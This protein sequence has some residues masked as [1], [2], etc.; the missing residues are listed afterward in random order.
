MRGGEY[1]PI[2]RR[3]YQAY[4]QIYRFDETLEGEA[5]EQEIERLARLWLETNHYL[6]AERGKDPE[7][8]EKQIFGRLML[9]DFFRR[10]VGWAPDEE[11]RRQKIDQLHQNFM[12]KLAIVNGS[13]CTQ[14]HERDIQGS[15]ETV[16]KL[17]Q[18]L[19]ITQRPG[20]RKL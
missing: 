20:G 8:G 7:F 17:M 16:D 2:S 18:R 6:N 12:R 3:L 1:N 10:E 4:L 13:L 5:R 19:A 14:S 9:Q 15:N 11:A